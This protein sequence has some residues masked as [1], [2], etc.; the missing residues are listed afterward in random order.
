MKQMTAAQAAEKWG[1]SL[2]RVQD[3][4][5]VGRIPGAERFGTHWMLPADAIRPVDGRHRDVRKDP[6]KGL[7]MPRRSPMMAMTDLYSVP[8]SAKAVSESLAS[9]PNA[10]ALF[11]DNIAYFQGRY[12]EVY[13]HAAELMRHHAGVF[14]VAGTGLLLCLCAI[15]KGD[16][17]LW[18]QAKHYI[19]EAPFRDPQ[20]REILSLVIAAAD[21]S[22]FR[23]Q[24]FPEWFERGSF[25]RLPADSHPMAKVFYAKWLY[26]VAF[27]V[28]SKQ[29]DLEGVEKLSLMRMVPNTIEP[30]IS[31]A[32][33]D[34][35]VIPEI[36][37]RLYCA[38]VYH[39]GGNRDLAVYH[40]D[41]AIA[42]ALPDRLYG[43]LATCWLRLDQLLEER[44]MLVSEE[45]AKQTKELYR[46]FL[47]GQ[48]ALAR[49][50][51]NRKMAASSLTARELEVAKL[52][53]FGFRNKEI[54]GMLGIQESTVKTTVQ[55]IMQ[56]TE[57]KDRSDFVLVI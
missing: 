15:W 1:I 18:V 42:L 20:D 4:C 41:K 21:S 26:V 7:R 17:T 50:I 9:N 22:V 52:V 45:A 23:V 48:E 10:K 46:Q 19:A 6:E 3:L 31:Q 29:Y 11:D 47:L 44:L 27:A 2:R 24:N 12:E 36:Y 51:R 55:K 32:V 56:K 5:R 53:A 54:A 57:V 28:A 49:V 16:S 34:K 39:N 33:V 13:T 25:E 8:G 14:A 37:L 35:T 40:I 43:I 38:L 30:L